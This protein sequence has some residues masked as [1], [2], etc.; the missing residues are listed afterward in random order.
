MG[1]VAER[2]SE[3]ACFSAAGPC[4][5]SSA[6]KPFTL[7]MQA[8]GS[9]ITHEGDACAS[10]HFER[11]FGDEDSC[12]LLAE[13]A[14]TLGQT[15]FHEDVLE[16]VEVGGVW[17]AAALAKEQSLI[18]FVVYGCFDGMMS[19]RYIAVIPEHRGHG[20]GR[21]LVEHVCQHC[22][23]RGV[24]QLSLFSQREMVEFYRAVGFQEVPEEEEGDSEDDLQ[25]PMIYLVP[26]CALKEAAKSPEQQA[27]GDKSATE[28]TKL[29]GPVP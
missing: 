18:G 9:Q 13:Q 15:E 24:R 7:S 11:I 19:L 27:N 5:A 1:N 8:S 16:I 3:H 4:A 6:S 29:N 12:S 25:V 10:L 2:G 20:H 22:A 21:C 14:R 17:Q 23:Q 26:P 28:T